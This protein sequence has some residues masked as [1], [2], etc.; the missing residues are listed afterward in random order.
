MLVEYVKIVFLLFKASRSSYNKVELG[1]N[2]LASCCRY[3]N[4]QIS[5][6]DL[7]VPGLSLA[8]LKAASGAQYVTWVKFC[9]ESI[10]AS[11]CSFR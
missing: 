5:L 2:V 10:E 11:Q 6:P 3:S 4:T 9:H 7:A 8:Q 1:L